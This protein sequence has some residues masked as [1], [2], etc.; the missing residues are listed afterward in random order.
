MANL[1]FPWG[2]IILALATLLAVVL[3]ASFILRGSLAI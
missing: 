1:G 2:R 3:A